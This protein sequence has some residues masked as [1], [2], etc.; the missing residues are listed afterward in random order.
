MVL[1]EKRLKYIVIIGE[2]ILGVE[3]AALLWPYL[4]LPFRNPWGV[5]GPLTLIKF[6]PSNN[7]LRFCVVLLIPVL[8]MVVIYF[9]NIRNLNNVVYGMPYCEK[10]NPDDPLTAVKRKKAISGLLAA[11]LILFAIVGGL[12]LRTGANVLND[13]D[14]YHDGETLGPAVSYEAGMVPYKEILFAHGLYEDPVRSVL[15][16]KLFGK[17][18]AAMRAMETI[19]QL[20]AWLLLCLFLYVLFQGNYLYIFMTLFSLMILNG[21][22]LMGWP[23]LNLLIFHPR[24][25]TI[26]AFLIV[27]M[28]LYDFLRKKRYS[29]SGFFFTCFFFSFIPVA[30]FVYSVDRGFYLIVTYIILVF[31]IYFVYMR[32]CSLKANFLFS[33]F[34]GLSSATLFLGA[35]L[36]W[37][38]ADFIKFTFLIMPKYKELMDG[39]AYPIRNFRG[40]SMILLIATTTFWLASKAIQT[41]HRNGRSFVVALRNF[42]DIYLIEFSLWM[43]SV[44]TFRSALGRAD[45]EHIAYSSLFTFILV[46]YILLKYFSKRKPSKELWRRS[47]S[48]KAFMF[49]FIILIIVFGGYNA[50]R[51]VADGGISKNFPFKYKDRQFYAY[52]S[53]SQA[54]SFLKQR[55]GRNENFVSMTNEQSWYYF[56]GRPAPTRFL[57]PI[58]AMPGFYQDEFINNLRTN[59]VKYIIYRNDSWWY[60]IDGIPNE[61]RLP[62]VY[63]FIKENYHP[64]QTIDG[65]EIWIRNT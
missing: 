19:D 11:L 34:L 28:Y 53:W 16:F 25:S 41:Y 10:S 55:L 13:F 27:L 45:S 64:Y 23:N 58:V 1:R 7:I 15:A 39:F 24:D 12:S 35:M 42:L 26:F 49:L 29:P 62:K 6:N 37:D 8:F 63:R 44:F 59:N 22:S 4:R 43:L 54:I 38:Y 17:S 48:R 32:K 33:S 20:V 51:V 61:A 65:Q 50:N 40:Y 60:A 18:I 30:A 21:L 14:T 52:R 46:A 5:T 56:V 2:F 47:K 3:V 9:L 36:R 57:S 31:L